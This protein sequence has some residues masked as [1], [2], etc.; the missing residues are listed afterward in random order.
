MK[1]KKQKRHRKILT[2]YTACSGFRKPFRV[3]CDG[4]FVHHLIV[5][6]ITPADK[7]L[8]NILTAP[9]KL[10]TTRCVLAELKRLDRSYSEAF[11]AAQQLI[12]ARCEHEKCAKA[13]A[14]IMEVVG[15]NNSEHF[16]VASQDTDLRKK[17]HEVP[18]VPLIF[19]LRNALFLEPP[20]AF[21]RQYV[22]TSEEGRSLMTKQEYQILKDRVRNRLAGE[23]GENSIAEITEQQDLEVQ[24]ISFQA[25]KRSITARNQMGIKD[26]P[27]FKRKRAKGPNPLS[28]KKKK[29]RENQNNGPLKEMKEGDDSV[30]RSR[31]RKRS[32]KRKIPAKSGS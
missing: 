24:P 26:K 5:N 18:G 27:Q 29:S 30:K 4:T 2:F 22:K 21:Q 25:E 9:V 15:Q 7:A 19:G 16:F 31:K 6:R 32:H 20:S 28:C 23:E 11:E 14:C 13:D 1:V 8:S 10:F 17:L 3:L 12:I